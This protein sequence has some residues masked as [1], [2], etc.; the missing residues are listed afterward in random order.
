MSLAGLLRDT[1]F[2][3]RRR[4]A[5]K[6]TDLECWRHRKFV[7]WILTINMFFSGECWYDLNYKIWK[8]VCND[9]AYVIVII[10]ILRFLCTEWSYCL[11]SESY[12]DS[13]RRGTLVRDFATSSKEKIIMQIVSVSTRAGLEQWDESNHGGAHDISQHSWNSC[14]RGPGNEMTSWTIWSENGY[15]SDRRSENERKKHN[16]RRRSCFDGQNAGSHVGHWEGVVLYQ[17]CHT[18]LDCQRFNMQFN[19]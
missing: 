14:G 4:G 10:E 15:V 8:L 6:W 9:K 13:R 12:R 3:E 5:K 2:R 11:S 19:P 18:F 17:Q 1:K 16:G 7:V